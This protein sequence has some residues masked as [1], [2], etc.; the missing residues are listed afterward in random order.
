M[1]TVYGIP[2]IDEY[3]TR[4][5]EGERPVALMW[6]LREPQHSPLHVNIDLYGVN[7]EM[8]NG[9][10]T[11]HLMEGVTQ[12]F[13]RQREGVFFIGIPELD[14]TALEYFNRPLRYVERGVV[15][16]F[17]Q[18][19]GKEVE[20]GDLVIPPYVAQDDSLTTLG[21]KFVG[22]GSLTA[23]GYKLVLF[24]KSEDDGIELSVPRKIIIGPSWDPKISYFFLPI[25]V[26]DDERVIAV[27]FVPQS[28]IEKFAENKNL[29][30]PN[31]IIARDLAMGPFYSLVEEP[32]RRALTESWLDRTLQSYKQLACNSPLCL[33]M[34]LHDFMNHDPVIENCIDVS[35]DTSC[36]PV[37]RGIND[38]PLDLIGKYFKDVHVVG[39][40]R[41]DKLSFRSNKYRKSF[42]G[43]LVLARNNI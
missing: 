4:G 34:D 25:T 37:Y 43:P 10:H 6:P 28:R 39:R 7:N 26:A 24:R 27:G 35:A 5:L 40:D 42:A 11:Y 21:Y 3:L 9:G 30:R 16:L 31:I 19:D 23:I 29:P 8:E 33:V 13:S 38:F 15:S 41:L 18:A 2:E 36:F 17:P 22:G 20:I 12:F 32:D 14:T 1:P